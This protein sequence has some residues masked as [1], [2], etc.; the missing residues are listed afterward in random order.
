MMLSAEDQRI[1][2]T[3]N[4]F[5]EWCAERTAETAFINI[6]FVL[7]QE[8]EHNRARGWREALVPNYN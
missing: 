6:C 5:R 8:F 7:H 3:A 4:L 1:E 2:K